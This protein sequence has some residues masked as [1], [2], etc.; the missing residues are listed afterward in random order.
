MSKINNLTRYLG[1][2]AAVNNEE[3]AH[4]IHQT[5]G[6]LVEKN[7]DKQW[8]LP[9]IVGPAKL[10]TSAAYSIRGLQVRLKLF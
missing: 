5:N 10:G 4:Y 2:L 3:T 7:F 1:A 9:T 6:S 8:S